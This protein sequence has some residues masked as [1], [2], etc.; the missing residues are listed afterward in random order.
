[1]IPLRDVIPWRT[2]PIVTLLLIAVNAL[3]FWYELALPP[4]FR[5][6][7]VREWGLVPAAFSWSSLATSVFLH[8]SW[9]QAA[10]NTLF[11]WLFGGSVEDRLGHGRF[12]AFYLL[13]GALACLVQLAVDLDS[14]VPT[15]GASGA[16]AG[17]M[18]AYFVLY[19]QSKMLTLVP[20]VVTL[21]VIEIRALYFLGLWFLLQLFSAVGTVA[22]TSATQGG[23]TFWTH[24]AGFIVGL[25]AVFLFRR[26]ERQKVEW[27]D[28]A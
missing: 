26:P 5:Q 18:G 1:M 14:L 6:Q 15:V 22:H 21:A 17:V 9:L 10:V 4:P 16:V 11:L 12:L 8:G 3:V 7:F 13:C 28:L 27:W 19:P 20:L 25:A 23:I 24:A 2:T